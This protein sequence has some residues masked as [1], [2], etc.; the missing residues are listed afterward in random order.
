M[1]E[2]TVAGVYVNYWFSDIPQ[3]LTALVVLVVITM[4][5]LANVKAYG[6]FEFWFALIKVVAIIGM[7]LLGFRNHLPLG[8]SNGGQ[9]IGFDNLWIHGGFIPNGIKGI[10]MS[11]V[12]VMFSI[13]RGRIGWNYSRGGKK[14]SKIDSI[15][16]Q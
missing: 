15:C 12:L 7:I 6:E 14:S 1:A 4:I 8:I 5:N 3:W 9:P 13:W 11:L 10:L 2:I 16:Y